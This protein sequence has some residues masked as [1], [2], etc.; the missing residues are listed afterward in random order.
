M[1]YL[2][3]LALALLLLACDTVEQDSFREQVVI[4]AYLIAGNPM[5][6]VRVSRTLPAFE[7]YT[8]ER[9]A[10][11]NAAVVITDTDA[12]MAIPFR[13]EQP[14][15]YRPHGNV[16]TIREGGRYAIQVQFN[17]RDEV[18]TAQTRIPLQFDILGTVPDEVVFQSSEQ[19][20]IGITATAPFNGQNVYIFNTIA[21]NPIIQNLTPFYFDLVDRDNADIEDFFNNSSGLINEGNFTINEDGTITLRIPWLGIAFFGV[22][23]IVINSVDKNINDLLRSQDVQLG[24]S[25]LP[26]GEIPNVIYNVDGGIGIFGSLSADTVT[27]RFVRPRP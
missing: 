21:Q 5:P 9:A 8:F 20:E 23:D 12:G 16:P 24:G 19:L 6:E 10:L 1:K 15:I 25:T 14:G 11:R 13:E 26:P 3:L 7:E 27:T 4:E 18:V 17:D 2:P 22:N